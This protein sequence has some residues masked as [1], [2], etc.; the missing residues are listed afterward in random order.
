MLARPLGSIS[1]LVLAD[2]RRGCAARLAHK[3]GPPRAASFVDTNRSWTGVASAIV[4]EICPAS[5][6]VGF[7]PLHAVRDC[8]FGNGSNGNG[9]SGTRRAVHDR[10]RRR[11]VRTG[12]VIRV[13]AVIGRGERAADHRARDKTRTYTAPA[14]S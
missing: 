5:G 3:K 8:I 14:P 12:V 1:R 10:A 6:V 7:E 9:I 13:I 2:V 4:T 11:H